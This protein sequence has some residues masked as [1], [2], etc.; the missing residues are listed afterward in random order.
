MTTSHTRHN[1][2]TCKRMAQDMMIR[3]MAIN[4]IDSY[5]YHVDKFEKF[6]VPKMADDA[7]LED[8]RSFQLHLINIRKVGFSS[9]N[10]AVCG[11]KFL[12]SVTLPRQWPVTMIPFGKRQKTLPTVLSG[13]QV[14]RL[15]QCTPYLKHRTFLTLLF[16]SGLRLSEAAR[17]KVADI[18]SQRMQLTIL[19]KGNKQRMLPLSPR[20]LVALRTY[21]KQHRPATLMFPGK[22]PDKPYAGTTIQKTI[23]RSARRAGIIKNVTP[24]TLRHSYA[25]GLLEAGVDILTISR[26]LGHASFSTTMKYLH[27]RRTHFLRSPSPLDWLPTRQLPRWEDPDNSKDNQTDNPN[28]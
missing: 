24:H 15:L 2:A 23:K 6:L 16:A 20:L 14:E 3:N 27:V 21:W 26:L 4:T 25:T 28:R 1:S 17:L 11:L 5:I 18:D 13:E 8:I 9:F 7:T 12:Y 10:Q 19:G 22:R